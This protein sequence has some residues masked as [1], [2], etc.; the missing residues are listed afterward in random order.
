MVSISIE[1]PSGEHPERLDG[2]KNQA[3]F[4]RSSIHRVDAGMTR[5]SAGVKRLFTSCALCVGT[6]AGEQRDPHQQPLIYRKPLN[7]IDLIRALI[8]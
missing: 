4:Y 6:R 3:A 7:L 1:S 2:H 8:F 5:S